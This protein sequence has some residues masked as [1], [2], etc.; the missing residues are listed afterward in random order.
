MVDMVHDGAYDLCIQYC[1]YGGVMTATQRNA[2][3]APGTV[4]QIP[5]PAEAGELSTLSRVDYVDA[6]LLESDVERTPEQWIRA[7]LQDAP[8]AVRTRLVCGWTE[9]GLKL[10]SPSSPRRVLGWKVHRSGAGFVLLAADGR[11]GLNAELLFRS[12]PRGLLFA[13]FVQHSNAAARNA[14]AAI[15]PT[16]HRVVRSLLTHAARRTAR[17][18]PE[19]DRFDPA[20]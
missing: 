6:F 17:D 16:H 15:T 14:W 4:S 3:S 20:L 12:E 18:R 10:G 11:L 9:L 7:V 5:L 19:P 2:T 1:I 13:T 8:L